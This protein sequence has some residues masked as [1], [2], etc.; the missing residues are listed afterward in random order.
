VFVQVAKDVTLARERMKGMNLSTGSQVLLLKDL[1]SNVQL[2]TGLQPQNTGSLLPQNMGNL[3]D[4][5]PNSSQPQSPTP[6]G[7]LVD[8]RQVCRVSGSSSVRSVDLRREEDLKPL[9]PGNEVI[10]LG[11]DTNGFP[12]MPRG[13]LDFDKSTS[14]ENPLLEV[15]TVNR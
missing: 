6:Y 10:N 8:S 2:A 1:P 7:L 12:N 9:S 11:D 4:E 14:V 3:L 13:S 15:E 5:N